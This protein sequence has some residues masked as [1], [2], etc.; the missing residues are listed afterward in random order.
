MAELFQ[1]LDQSLTLSYM[2][3]SLTSAVELL[4]DDLLEIGEYFGLSD[5]EI[6]AVEQKELAYNQQ[7]EDLFG[8]HT[9]YVFHVKLMTCGDVTVGKL[10]S[11][12]DEAIVKE[13]VTNAFY[14]D[15]IN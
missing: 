4:R 7:D 8:G 6:L 5:A 1:G 15:K 9:V 13:E 12:I 3:R 11:K 14:I 10:L 2:A